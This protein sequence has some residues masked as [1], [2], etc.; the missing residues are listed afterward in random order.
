MRVN[1]ISPVSF[2]YSKKSQEYLEKNIEQIEEP[3]LKE[4]IKSCSDT[5][6]AMEDTIRANERK[7]GSN[8]SLSNYVD[9]FVSM[10]DTLTTYIMLL[11]DDGNKYVQSEYDYYSSSLNRCKERENNW[12][13]SVIDRLKFWDCNLGKSK[14]EMAKELEES[15]KAAAVGK[16]QLT[17]VIKTYLTGE[18]T[19]AA[20]TENSPI[21]ETLQRTEFSPKGMQ[22]VMGMEDLKEELIENVIKPV[23]NPK[24]ARLDLEEY[25]KRIPT[26]ILLYG[27]PGCGKTYIIEALAAET[28]SEV[29]IMNSAN[30]GSKFVN[31]T[32]NN[33]K[34]AFDYVYKKG[35]ESDKPVFMFMDEID[36][37]TSNRDAHA[38]NEDIKGVAT[39]LKYIEGAKAHNVIVIGATNKYDM[40]DPAIRRRFDTKRY[41]GLP[42]KK[43][44]MSLLANNLSKKSKGQK[45]LEDKEALEVL[46]GLSDGYSCHS[47]NIIADDASMLALKRGRADISL[48]DFDNAIS[49]TDEEKIDEALY[50]PKSNKKTI[51]FAP[52]AAMVL[53][54]RTDRL[55]LDP[56]KE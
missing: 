40:I 20:T 44:R 10:K 23:N 21:V 37:M 47:I 29:Y 15:K 30:T 39:L 6:N 26:G 4:A 16:A 34:N 35:D 56:K 7:Y 55:T 1:N 45:L 5:C 31:Q 9:F 43:Q 12:R 42:D 51:G 3:E 2:G 41:V 52:S 33:I 54:P 48:E 24:Q 38:S 46:A 53:K 36:A 19:N 32:A 28:D 8:Y 25:G 22:D 17:D 18:K 14:E 49:E 11:F 50:K 27:P 13:Q